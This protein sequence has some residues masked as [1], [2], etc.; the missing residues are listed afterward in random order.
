MHATAPATA[1]WA[2]AASSLA[3]SVLWQVCSATQG[4]SPPSS[5]PGA[6]RPPAAA[7]LTPVARWWTRNW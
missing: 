2:V 1:I 4:G 7:D 3:T 5:V 6:A